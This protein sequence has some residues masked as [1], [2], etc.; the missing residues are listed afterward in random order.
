MGS[1]SGPVRARVMTHAEL[2]RRRAMNS[3]EVFLTALGNYLRHDL[4]PPN[5]HGFLRRDG[6]LR[7]CDDASPLASLSA[8]LERLRDALVAGR[9]EDVANE[10]NR[11]AEADHYVPHSDRELDY[12][13]LYNEMVVRACEYVE[14]ASIEPANV[15]TSDEP[16]WKRLT[17][18]DQAQ[19]NDIAILDG[20]FYRLRSGAATFLREL[21]SMRGNLILAS[22]LT[23]KCGRRADYIFNRLDAA[24]HSIIDRPTKRGQGYRMH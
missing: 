16:V 21:Q 22:T 20:E 8:D 13:R 23:K 18:Q 17:I 12:P 1:V 15:P 9:H 19:G 11:L 5:R 4:P 24:L 10:L 3:V 2:S 6:I 14:T 7:I